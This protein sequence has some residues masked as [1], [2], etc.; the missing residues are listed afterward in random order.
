MNLYLQVEVCKKSMA[1]LLSTNF[2]FTE[3]LQTGETNEQEQRVL[4]LCCGIL[5][6][7]ALHPSNRYLF[8]FVYSMKFWNFKL[9]S[10]LE[11]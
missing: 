1:L 9:P 11:A 6:N 10:Y 2:Y 8:S 5:Q 4:A 7:C 3:L